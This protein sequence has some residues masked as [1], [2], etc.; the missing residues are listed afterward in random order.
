MSWIIKKDNAYQLVHK[1]NGQNSRRITKKNTK[2]LAVIGE[3]M[4]NG[5][6]RS[7]R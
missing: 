4:R 3:E 7:T 5:E 1:Q 2:L 6:R